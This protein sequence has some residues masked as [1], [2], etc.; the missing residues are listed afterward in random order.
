M[1]WQRGITLKSKRELSIMREAGKINALALLTAVEVAE[2]GVTTEEI[3]AVVAEVLRKNGA[4]PAFL[5]YGEPYPYP[6]VSTVSV[7]DELVHGIPGKRRLKDG[8]I[9]SIDCGSIVDGF[10][11]DSAVT[12]GVG[13]ISDET[14][15]LL[16]VTLA[17]LFA[18]I[19]QMRLGNR[20]GDVSAAIQ[21][22][23]EG[24]GYNVVRE[25]TGHG[26]GRNMH[27]DP[28]V[29]NY[30]VPGK[31]VELRN[32]MTIA[33]E[34]MVLTGTCET[35]VLGDQWCVASKDGKLTAHYEHTV[36]ITRV[37]PLVLTMLDDDLDD[38]N[39]I[40]YNEYFMGWIEPAL[41]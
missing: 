26:V 25:Y 19:D 32:G 20:T 10:V 12:I 37:G 9:V 24:N 6:A 7:N 35:R 40:R 36:A 22:Y 1:V 11:A 13:E 23:V 28:Q 18:G 33:I 3:D 27:E 15:R 17:A 4:K 16:D 38:G 31:G 21:K 2:P 29:P 14:Q 8:D 41:R 34:P 30:G 39:T 5:G